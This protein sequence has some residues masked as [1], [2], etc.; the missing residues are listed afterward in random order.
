MIKLY[1]PLW[2]HIILFSTLT[3]SSVVVPEVWT[4]VKRQY[5]GVQEAIQAV[6]TSEVHARLEGPSGA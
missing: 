6:Q 1:L 2:K 5:N 4:P 3:R